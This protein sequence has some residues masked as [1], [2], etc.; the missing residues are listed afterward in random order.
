MQMQYCVY[1]LAWFLHLSDIFLTSAN[2]AILA[3]RTLFPRHL[4]LLDLRE[5][6]QIQA[7]NKANDEGKRLFRH[8]KSAEATGAANIPARMLT[9][10]AGPWMLRMCPSGCPSAAQVPE[11]VAA[12][13]PHPVVKGSPSW[14]LHLGRLLRRERR[15]IDSER[16]EKFSFHMLS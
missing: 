16:L 14:Y 4:Q 7:G 11:E 3:N 1:S 8:K 5:A 2:S 9:L 6:A 12:W 10:A 13:I 15:D